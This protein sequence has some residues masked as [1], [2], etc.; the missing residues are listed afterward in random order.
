MQFSL[1]AIWAIGKD[2]I[3][4]FLRRRKRICLLVVEDNPTDAE[5]TEAKIHKLG[6]AC[7]VVSSAEGAFPLLQ[8]KQH[9]VVLLDL[10][11]P[12]ESGAHLAGRILKRFPDTHVVIMAGDGSDAA[13]V[14]CGMYFGL[15]LKPVTPDALR[16]IFRKPKK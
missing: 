13:R 6:W 8:E 9:P 14:L 11:L 1:A 7:D 16:D 15:I 5:L 3:G 12:Y 4:W 2:V 10:R